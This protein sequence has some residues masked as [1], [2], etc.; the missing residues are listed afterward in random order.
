LSFLKDQVP[1]MEKR[2]SAPD[3]LA[4]VQPVSPTDFS[5]IKSTMVDGRA[6]DIT[7]FISKD[8]GYIFIAKPFYPPGLFRAPSGG[9]HRGE[10]FEIGVKR[11]AREETGVEIE[12]EK[13]ILRIDVSFQSPNDTLEWTSHIFKAHYLSGEIEPIDRHEISAARLIHLDEI[14]TFNE[15]MLAT[16][17]GGFAYRAFLT[18]EALKRL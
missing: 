2:F 13:Y 11:E 6:H 8:D 12:L 15:I 1:V 18:D 10:D 3:Y 5:Y 17:R 16:G 14:P 4:R 9:V 7:F